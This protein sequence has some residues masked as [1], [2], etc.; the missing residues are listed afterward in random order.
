MR[1][2]TIYHSGDHSSYTSSGQHSLTKRR[3]CSVYCDVCRRDRMY[4]DYYL[5]HKAP[6]KEKEEVEIKKERSERASLFI[7]LKGD[8]I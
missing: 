1:N 5:D 3:R 7:F 2:D 8:L 4:G 6:D